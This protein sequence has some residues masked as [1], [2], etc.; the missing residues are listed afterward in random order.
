[1]LSEETTPLLPGLTTLSNQ[2]TCCPQRQR[3]VL[4][5]WNT[6]M[7]M[8]SQLNTRMCCHGRQW[9]N[10]PCRQRF[11]LL[12]FVVWIVNGAL[13]PHPIVPL[14]PLLTALCCQHC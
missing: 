13:L 9:Q 4:S 12:R 11:A 14:S 1:M 3:N 6:S 5:Q 2:A 10:C 7:L 8:L